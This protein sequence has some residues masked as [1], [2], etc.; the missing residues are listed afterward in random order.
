MSTFLQEIAEHPATSRRRF[1]GPHSD[2]YWDKYE[3]EW[4]ET[5]ESLRRRI[6]AMLEA[7]TKG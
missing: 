2:A 4:L 1:D 7:S 5:D 6:S 3:E